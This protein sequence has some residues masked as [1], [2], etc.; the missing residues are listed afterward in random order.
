MVGSAW[1]T[2]LTDLVFPLLLPPLALFQL[3][4]AYLTPPA[5]PPPATVYVYPSRHTFTEKRRGANEAFAGV[6]P[7]LQPFVCYSRVSLGRSRCINV[8]RP[9][10]SHLFKHTRTCMINREKGEKLTS[11]K[12]GLGQAVT[13]FGKGNSKVD[14]QE[15]KAGFPPH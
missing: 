3:P 9:L 13:G 12:N 15:R 7:A 1:L 10:S 4:S 6:I 8:S 2:P 11:D 5:P 14:F